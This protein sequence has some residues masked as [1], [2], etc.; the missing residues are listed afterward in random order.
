[1]DDYLLLR[2]TARSASRTAVRL[3]HRR[4]VRAG[5]R[6]APPAPL[7]SSSSPP[8]PSTATALSLNRDELATSKNRE[9]ERKRRRGTPAGLISLK[10]PI[11]PAV[12]KN[13]RVLRRFLNTA[14]WSGGF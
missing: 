5:A 9:E 10:T 13:R 2:P 8:S 11:P 6:R 1:V 14:A 4:V 12:F 3:P 7:P